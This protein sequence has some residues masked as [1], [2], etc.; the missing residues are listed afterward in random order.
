MQ[1]NSKGQITQDLESWLNG[2]SQAGMRIFQ[3]AYTRLVSIATIQ[4]K[5]IGG[6]TLTPNEVV[7]EA[8]VRLLKA[9][10]NAKPA[11][12]LQFYRLSSHVFRLT[13]VDYLRAKL[14]K[15]RDGQLANLEILTCSEDDKN[16]LQ[17]FMLL[18]DF[19]NK[20]QR[21][22]EVFELNK[23]IGFSL[24]ETAELVK[25]SKATVSRDVNFARHWLASRL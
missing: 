18:E 16:L 25:S 11:N 19:E 1:E 6:I 17:I 24:A 8:Y 15:K 23:I 13:C 14:A 2:S 7:H 9:M 20:Y 5:N 12:S 10:E 22:A 3:N 21:Q 4:H